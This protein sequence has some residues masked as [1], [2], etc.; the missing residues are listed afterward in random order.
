MY[1]SVSRRGVCWLAAAVIVLAAAAIPAS[2]QER[3][4]GLTGTV[5]DASGAVLSGRH[6]GASPTSRPARSSRP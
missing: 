1:T 5:T 2:A 4:S 6:R 3:F